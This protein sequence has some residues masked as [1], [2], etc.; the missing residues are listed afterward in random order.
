MSEIKAIKA[1]RPDGTT[2]ECTVEIVQ[3]P[4]S[5]LVFFGAGFQGREFSGGDLFDAFTSLRKTL[6]EAGVQLLCAGARPEVFPSGMSRDMGGGRKAYITKLG[7]P[8]LRTDLVDI[9]DYSDAQSVG[10]VSDQHAFHERWVA[11]LRK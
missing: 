1:R 10:S 5:K 11:S 3:N 2:E 4:Q 6:E 9:F 7:N 8:A